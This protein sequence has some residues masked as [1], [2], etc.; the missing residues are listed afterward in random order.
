MKYLVS[1][2]FRLNG[3]AAENEA[4][5]KRVLEVYSKWTPPASATYHHLLGKVDSS[6]GYA[7]VETD[8]PLDL[9][10]VT[11]KF[12]FAADDHVDPVLDIADSVRVAQEAIEFRDSIS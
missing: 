2:T 5:A 10:D 6:G 4:A 8:N 1:F 11:S 12:S 3:S 9:A 7:L